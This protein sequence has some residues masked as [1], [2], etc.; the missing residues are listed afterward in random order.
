VLN[1]LD[2]GPGSLRDTIGAAASGVTI[3]FDPS[4]AG[5]TITLT[6]GELLLTKNLDIEGP[7]ADSLTVSGNN[8]S[9]VFEV[10]SG[11]NDSISGLTVANGW[12]D[13]GDVTGAGVKNAGFLIMSNSTVA[14]N[15]ARQGSGGAGFGGGIYNLG[16]LIVQDSLITGNTAGYSDNGFGG[17]IYSLG[18]LTVQDSLIS[19]NTAVGGGGGIVDSGPNGALTVVNSTISNDV[20]ALRGGG[21]LLGGRGAVVIS[22]ST[23]SGNW[24]QMGGGIGKF[25]GLGPVTVESSTISDNQALDGGGI[26]V[27]G[28]SQALT[29]SDSTVSGNTAEDGGGIYCINS[30]SV[31]VSNSTISGNSATYSGGGGI[32]LLPSGTLN[33]RNTIVAGNQGVSGASD[34]NGGLA[35][36]GYNLIGN[37]QGGSG[38]TDTDVLNVDPMLGL[39]QENGGP[40]QT[41][42][43]LPGS[44]ALSA[45]DPAQLGVAD[46]R[47]VVRRG[48][49]NIGAYQASASA[50]VLSA[51]GTVQAGVP[52][53]VTVT[54]VDPYGQ[55]A[56]GYA[57]RVTF[58]T[59][60]SDPGVVLPP[61][62]TFTSDDNGSVTFS[63]GFTLVTPGDQTLTATDTADSTITGNVT[64]TVISGAAPWSRPPQPSAVP[65]V[66]PVLVRPQGTAVDPL[67][68]AR[69]EGGVLGLWSL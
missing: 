64:V 2:N 39:L 61:D 8:A 25:T 60:D 34:L 10:A 22:S 49:V 41:M 5:Q 50:F 7:G 69:A 33:M 67:A 46:Q 14:N 30:G 23:I 13:G 37:T 53:D 24:A 18:T 40:T 19:S 44:P 15:F 56:L 63:G 51:P 52:F 38:F 4:L 58:S 29:L 17:G 26:A 3:D 65:S 43:L 59:T 55:V 36:S 31:S 68:A 35:S 48:G 45:G 66:S 16:T 57:G 47:G 54:A 6:S 21:L 32:W 9:R 1:N 62:Y 20:G 42:A 27:V 28:Q 11:A 12:L